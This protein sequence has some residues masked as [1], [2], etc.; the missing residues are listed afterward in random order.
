M[1]RGV[2]VLAALVAEAQTEPAQTRSS[3]AGPGATVAPAAYAR[4][5]DGTRP[6]VA[7]VAAAATRE[8]VPATRRRLSRATRRARSRDGCGSAGASASSSSRASVGSATVGVEA[9]PSS[10]SSKVSAGS[11]S[12][13]PSSRTARRRRLVGIASSS[14]ISEDHAL[15]D[16]DRHPE[17]RRHVRHGIGVVERAVLPERGA[18]RRREHRRR[19]ERLAGALAHRRLRGGRV[20]RNL[21]HHD[22]G[23]P[24]SLQLGLGVE[25][26]ARRQVAGELGEVG[27]RLAQVRARGDQRRG[28]FER[29]AAVAGDRR[30]ERAVGLGG[31]DEGADP[32]SA[33]AWAATRA[34]S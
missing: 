6:T 23:D 27:I 9:Q 7:M 18:P 15:P 2:G 28:L 1:H 25:A 33:S 26:A 34:G 24:Q 13:G 20:I 5:R 30:A 22:E 12:S 14:A 19:V 8:I 17:L 16:R 11:D 29:R 31:Q 32:G 4:G 10:S 21:R 3:S